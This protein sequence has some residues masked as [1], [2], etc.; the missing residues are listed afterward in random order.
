MEQKVI[1]TYYFFYSKCTSNFFGSWH[2]FRSPRETVWLCGHDHTLHY[3][4]SS[5]VSE[6]NLINAIAVKGFRT[7]TE[8]PWPW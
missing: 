1:F 4:Y 3:D 5:H 6:N 8:Q 2:K 7:N